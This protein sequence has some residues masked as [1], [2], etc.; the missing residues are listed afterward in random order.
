M[1][2]NEIGKTGALIYLQTKPTLLVQRTLQKHTDLSEE[3]AKA[4]INRY[5]REAKKV[6][7]K[8]GAELEKVRLSN[9]FLYGFTT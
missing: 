8:Y 7:F 6:T 5:I 4:L 1:F 3:R 9:N 2:N